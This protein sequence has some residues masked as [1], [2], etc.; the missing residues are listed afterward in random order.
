MIMI[1]ILILIILLMIAKPMTIIPA[2]RG[3]SDLGGGPHMIAARWK[4]VRAK[5]CAP[6]ITNMNIHRKM[7]SKVHDDF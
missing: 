7:P 5:D 4:R 3:T 2:D 1:L 6:E